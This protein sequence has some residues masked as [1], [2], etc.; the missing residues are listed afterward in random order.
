MVAW[1]YRGIHSQWA[2]SA[3]GYSRKA[4]V[5]LWVLEHE[6][7]KQQ[8]VGVGS[9]S[10]VGGNDRIAEKLKHSLSSSTEREW[11]KKLCF[12]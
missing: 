1:M 4:N 11:L 7:P 10:H 12:R 5:S 8:S 2:E 9:R 6:A 3:D